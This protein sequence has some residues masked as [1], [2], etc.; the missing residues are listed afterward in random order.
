LEKKK[1]KWA[2]VKAPAEKSPFSLEKKRPLG[3]K[4]TTFAKKKYLEKKKAF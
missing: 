1:A 4:E 2:Q 3:S